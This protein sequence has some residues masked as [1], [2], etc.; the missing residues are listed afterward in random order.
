[1]STFNYDNFSPKNIKGKIQNIPISTAANTLNDKIDALRE[2]GTDI[3][4]GGG[5]KPS[6]A[7]IA[8]AAIGA[9]TAGIGAFT[10][11]NKLQGN[12]GQTVD[13]I[14]NANNNLSNINSG[15]IDDFINSTYNSGPLALTS[16]KAI[17]GKSA[18]DVAL[19]SIQA[20]LSG[21]SAGS[22]GGLWGM[23][24]G[25]AAGQIGN[26]IGNVVAHNKAKNLAEQTNLVIDDLNNTRTQQLNNAAATTSMKAL[27]NM[28]GTVNMA[29]L[30]GPINMQYTGVNSPFGNRF[31]EGG[32][33]IKESNRGKFT[34]LANTH[35]MTP[36]QM[37]NHIFANKDNYSATQIKRANFVRNASK[38]HAE[39]GH[40]DNQFNDFRNGIT[41]YNVG[42]THEENPNEGIQVGVDPQGTPNLVEEGE[43]NYNDYIFSNR[44]KVPKQFKKQYGLGNSKKQM[45]YADAAKKLQKESEERPLD[46][47]SKRGLDAVLGALAESQ[48]DT[49]FK[50]Q[51]QDP[52]FRQQ[53]M[54]AMAQQAQQQGVEEGQEGLE[55]YENTSQEQQPTEKEL[56]AMQQQVAQQGQPFAYGGKKG[57]IFG[58][59]G[60]FSNKLNNN[61]IVTV[62]N[63]IDE[64][65]YYSNPVQVDLSKMAGIVNKDIPA[66]NTKGRL[67]YFRGKE[68][69]GAYT[70]PDW[71]HNQITNQIKR[72]Y[73][74]GDVGAREYVQKQAANL[75]MSEEDFMKNLDT[76]RLRAN[77]KA[78]SGITGGNGYVS[79]DYPKV[80]SSTGIGNSR[81][82]VEKSKD[83][84]KDKDENIP[85][86][87]I[88]G[89]PTWMRYAPI[90][91]GAMGLF[92]KPNFTEADRLQAAVDKSSNY[93]PISGHY[94]GD[95]LKYTPYDINYAANQLRQ[96]GN[97]QLR[98]IANMSGGNRAAAMANMAATNYNTQIAVG[99]ALRQAQEYNDKLRATVGEFNRGTNQYNA[100]VANQTDQFNAQQRAAAKSQYLNG[101]LQVAQMRE[102]Q[103]L[104][105]DQARSNAISGIGNSIGDIGREN[106][107]MNQNLAMLLSGTYGKFREE[108]LPLILSM[109]GISAKSKKGKQL[110]E[111][112]KYHKSINNKSND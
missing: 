74:I 84:D 38:W 47:I 59:P 55:G 16:T 98:N 14:N 82:I 36:L 111:Y 101:M 8:G 28:M 70:L 60:D 33:N 4:T 83:K 103:R 31:N 77:D 40:L 73:A 5:N 91:T 57:N 112:L 50:K 89:L 39:G 3:D 78:P 21:A 12:Y 97:T 61:F 65:D 49:R 75:G 46:P 42:G 68:Y 41:E 79:A 56:A 96:Q 67:P 80:V 81:P 58:G 95:Y 7:A 102:K 34:A 30:G 43:V 37:A 62:P 72:G 15:S 17:L 32:I 104:L 48:E 25:A 44:L 71:E 19:G 93:N 11:A 66:A 29:A 109:N 9:A 69:E 100:T 20:G 92:S 64:M 106:F 51:M 27:N 26:A 1:M 45:S 24:A 6:K 35:G 85:I 87:T 76:L 105:A 18:G 10:Q 88:K 52:Q 63:I 110:A 99:N 86:P 2:D 54:Q 107:T 94:I 22:S 53:A 13:S 23:L 108:F 90:I